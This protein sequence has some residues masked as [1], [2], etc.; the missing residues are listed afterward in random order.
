MTRQEQVDGLIKANRFDEVQRAWL[1]GLPEDQF[2][3]INKAIVA[4]VP[5]VE[6]PATN[7]AVATTTE[8]IVKPVASPEVNEAAEMMAELKGAHADTVL[9][10]N[11][12]GF[13]REELIAM[14]LKHL[15]K[16]AAL[17]ANT[18]QALTTD[19]TGLGGPGGGVQV[20]A[21]ETAESP[22][23]FPVAKKA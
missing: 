22:L 6:T 20:N 19:R 5:K 18:E 16:L 1:T 17:A 14:P 2:V 10:V 9:K 11:G 21:E 12:A 7:A 4:Q 13:T 15:K 23:V 3:A 8:T